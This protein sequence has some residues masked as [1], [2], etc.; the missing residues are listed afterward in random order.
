M[1][2]RRTARRTCAATT[3]AYGTLIPYLLTVVSN[4][5]LVSTLIHYNTMFAISETSNGVRARAWITQDE[6]S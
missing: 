4:R 6:F 1:A 5:K 3:K 2:E